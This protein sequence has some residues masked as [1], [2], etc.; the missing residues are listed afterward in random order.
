VRHP[1]MLGFLIAFWS[2]AGDDPGSP[3][4]RG[5][6]TGYILMGI[7]FEERDLV[8]RARGSLPA[9]PEAVPMLMP[10]KGDGAVRMPVPVRVT[11]RQA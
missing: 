3:S 10:Y 1:L 8:P 6:T 11:A 7:Q 4:V 5:L 2:D 9:L